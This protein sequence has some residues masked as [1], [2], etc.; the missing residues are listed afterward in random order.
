MFQISKNA[1]FS[2]RA[3]LWLMGGLLLL[4]PSWGYGINPTY[5]G[6][7]SNSLTDLSQWSEDYR[8]G[9]G[10][11]RINGS[12]YID[13]TFHTTLT[14][15]IGTAGNNLHYTIDLREGADVRFTGNRPVISNGNSVTI[16]MTGGSLVMT[17]NNC[18]YGEGGNKSAT[19]NLSGGTLTFSGLCGSNSSGSIIMTQQ[20]GKASPTW[21]VAFGLVMGWRGNTENNAYRGVVLQEAGTAN[22]L[23]KSGQ[24]TSGSGITFTSVNM[25]STSETL[26]SGQYI[27]D[28]GTLNTYRVWSSTGY[29]EANYQAMG[30]GVNYNDLYDSSHPSKN[31]IINGGRVNIVNSSNLNG[32]NGGTLS[33][34]TYFGGGILNVLNIDATKML[35]DTFVQNGGSLSPDGGSEVSLEVDNTRTLNVNPLGISSTTITGNYQL[36]NA[37]ILKLDIGNAAADRTT[38]SGDAILKGTIR[39]LL[40]SADLTSNTSGTLL[41]VGGTLDKEAVTLQTSSLV[42]LTWE[43]NTLKYTVSGQREE[44]YWTGGTSGGE[45]WDDA[46]WSAPGASGHNLVFGKTGYN[47]QTTLNSAFSAHN[48]TMADGSGSTAEL[49]IGSQGTL[50]VTG[51]LTVGKGGTARLNLQEGGSISN[52]TATVGQGAG[53]DGTL[54]ILGGTHSFQQMDAG[55]GTGTGTFVLGEVSNKASTPTVTANRLFLAGEGMGISRGEAYFYGGQM[56]AGTFDMA[57]AER[58][59][60]KLVMDGGNLI[61]NG[62]FRTSEWVHSHSTIE[63]K[64]GSLFM[65]GQTTWGSHGQTKVDISGGTMT[66]LG[67]FVLNFYEQD[68]VVTQTGGTVNLWANSTSGWGVRT[69]PG[70]IANYSSN[71][72]NALHAG[73]QFGNTS[74][75]SLNMRNKNGNQT[76]NISGG[77][78]NTLRI[79]TLVANYE[80]NM[81]NIS[82]DAVVN[83]IEN[84]ASADKYYGILAVPTSMTGGTLNVATIYAQGARYNAYNELVSE[85]YHYMLNGTFVQEGGILSPDGGSRVEDTFVASNTGISSTKIFGNYTLT[86]TGA[87]KL[88]IMQLTTERS[89][90]NDFIEVTGTANIGGAGI[91]IALAEEHLRTHNEVLVLTAGNVASVLVAEDGWE[92]QGLN[93]GEKWTGRISD[94]GKS[95]YAVLSSGDSAVWWNETTETWSNPNLSQATELIVGSSTIGNS[96]TASAVLSG[97]L[98]LNVAMHLGYDADTEGH[99]TLDNAQMTAYHINTGGAGIGTFEVKENASLSVSNLTLAANAG[100]KGTFQSSGNTTINNLDSS[101]NGTFHVLGG[102]TRVMNGATLANTTIS[103]T[104][105]G[106]LTFDSTLDLNEV[107]VEVAGTAKLNLHQTNFQSGTMNLSGQSKTSLSFSSDLNGYN[108]F[109]R[110]G[111]TMT[112]TLS[113]SAQMDIDAENQDSRSVKFGASNSVA[114]LNVQDNAVLVLG[115]VSQRTV[116]ESYHLG[117][118]GK[119]VMNQTGGTVFSSARLFFGEVAS[120]HTDVYNLSG[121][122]FYSQLLLV[123]GSSNAEFNISGTGYYNAYGQFCVGYGN[124][125]EA[126]VNQTGGVA[127]IWGDQAGRWSSDMGIQFG[128]SGWG[129]S[130]GRYNLSGGQLNTYRIWGRANNSSPLLTLSGGELNIVAKA[131]N[132]SLSNGALEVPISMTGGVLNAVKIVGMG[133]TAGFDNSGKGTFYQ[134]GGILSPDGGSVVNET[135]AIGDY[136]NITA[137]KFVANPTQ[138]GSTAIEGNYVLEMTEDSKSSPTVLLDFYTRD[139]HS[140]YITSTDLITVSGNLTLG[141][142]VLLMLRFNDWENTNG[143]YE[144]VIQVGGNVTGNFSGI[145]FLGVSD[146]ILTDPSI[147]AS[148]LQWSPDGNLSIHLGNDLGVPEPGTWALLLLGGGMLVFLTGRRKGL[149][150]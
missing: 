55:N 82:G 85:N 41:T 67:Q 74:G 106:V 25:A 91:Q 126:V 150:T 146:T 47:A 29:D 28:S 14:T 115:R 128:G 93:P 144:N 114:N 61:V 112:L 45:M 40:N 107:T 66:V 96:P 142:D 137:Q 54:A 12:G 17:A 30:S 117:D 92:R 86:G 113:D 72:A 75:G 119:F 77:E 141:E 78:L 90:N 11:I 60:A 38:V 31:L 111:G 116:D 103:A 97:N 39:V 56:T 133:E 2:I 13:G 34:P 87:I 138:I 9:T 37:G 69:N 98:T 145:Q 70:Y 73:L 52:I 19:I 140:T 49:T 147:L 33:V 127:D 3:S 81:L 134:R 18:C 23:G 88:D 62:Q 100:A 95:L 118:G 59:Q 7:E 139:V 123:S 1:P 132:T 89:A 43:G 99:V 8:T 101:N 83:I 122:N 143:I 32:G 84:G 57:Y 16:N 80:S 24:W 6:T 108:Y 104:N 148:I 79:S 27:I 51:N 105:N 68:D 5:T 120:P 10:E 135:V 53:S 110:N 149:K 129:R 15:V 109:G 121:G 64:S 42:N 125:T 50:A 124:N 131:E 130:T 63:L 35:N 65:K 46:N 4:I 71:N 21:N 22:I 26:P 136:G 76:W 58:S 48:F 102:E 20:E 94:D 36:E 44:Y